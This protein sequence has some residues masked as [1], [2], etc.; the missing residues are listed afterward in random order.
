M[1]KP[2]TILTIHPMT[3]PRHRCIRFSLRTLFVVVT[4]LRVLVGVQRKPT[5]PSAL[6]R[7][8]H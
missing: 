3:A 2:P 6:C 1:T 5:I 7:S 4:V 8:D